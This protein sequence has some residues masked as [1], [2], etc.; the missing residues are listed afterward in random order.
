[1][2]EYSRLII[3]LLLLYN[4]LA[5]FADI[6]NSIRSNHFITLMLKID[7]EFKKKY[8]KS[9]DDSRSWSFMINY[10]YFIIIIIGYF[11]GK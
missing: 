4:R 7:V 5:K 1:M 3:L 8:L 9:I 11:I 6:Q 2:Y 10:Y